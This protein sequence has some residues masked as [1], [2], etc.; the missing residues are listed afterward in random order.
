MEYITADTGSK[1]LYIEKESI[2]TILTRPDICPVPGAE[3]T[4]Q[5]LS[6]YGENLVV[7]YRMGDREEA[8]CGVVL[9]ADGG[10][11][12]IAALALGEEEAA[13]EELEGILPGVW[14]KKS[15]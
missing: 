5:G 9:E 8:P 6:F 10:L 14:E 1:K 2:Q 4:I 3:D 11:M 12:G 15:D 7:F 13:R